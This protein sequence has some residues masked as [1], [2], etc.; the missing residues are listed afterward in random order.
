MRAPMD[1]HQF[2]LAA[3]E[4]LGKADNAEAYDALVATCDVA[5]DRSAE[6]VAKSREELAQVQ[7][8]LAEVRGALKLVRSADATDRAVAGETV[9]E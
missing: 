5:R 4:H 6:E 2:A 3:R 7:G 8:E 1:D 9:T